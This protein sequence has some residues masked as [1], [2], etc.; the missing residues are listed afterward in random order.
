MGHKRIVLREIDETVVTFSFE[1][2]R[3]ATKFSMRTEPSSVGALPVPPR[4]RS[5]EAA[6]FARFPWMM[7]GSL[8]WILSA[9]F[10]SRSGGVSIEGFAWRSRRRL[11]CGA[12]G[13]LE[14]KDFDLLEETALGDADVAG[15]GGSGERTGDPDIRIRPDG[16]GLIAQDERV[17]RHE[18][19]VDMGID[20]IG[21]KN[22]A[23]SHR[24]C[25]RKD[26]RRIAGW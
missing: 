22:A 19:D 18:S 2:G 25:R 11:G 26:C 15:D 4:F 13:E 16:D 20:Q 10:Q 5:D 9:N 12:A 17:L 23:A 21:K 1:K 6:P 3:E 8:V 7:N 14:G 24:T